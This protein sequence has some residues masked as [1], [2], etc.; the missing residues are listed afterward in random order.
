MA[1]QPGICCAQSRLD[2][3]FAPTQAPVN[4]QVACPAPTRRSGGG[5]HRRGPRLYLSSLKRQ[6]PQRVGGS[7]L[8]A[9]P[10]G[11]RDACNKNNKK[12][13]IG[14]TGGEEAVEARGSEPNLE[15]K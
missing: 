12:G 3:I 4:E 13:C 7:G 15:G 9:R 10:R 1:T 6:A 2:G 8:R 14:G 11:G 5:H